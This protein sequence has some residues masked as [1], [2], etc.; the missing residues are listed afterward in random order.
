MSL[1]RKPLTNVTQIIPGNGEEALFGT[2]YDDHDD[3]VVR[4][5]VI[6][7]AWMNRGSTARAEIVALIPDDDTAFLRRVDDWANFL[8]VE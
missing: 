3:V 2:A 5:E 6:C 4:I 1:R 7:W 8:R